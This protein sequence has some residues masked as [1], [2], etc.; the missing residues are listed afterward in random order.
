MY[1]FSTWDKL[2]SPIGG[3]SLAF[4][5]NIQQPWPLWCSHQGRDRGLCASCSMVWQ[6]S[7]SGSRNLR[8]FMPQREGDMNLFSQRNLYSRGDIWPWVHCSGGGHES[9]SQPCIWLYLSKVHQGCPQQGYHSGLSGAFCTCSGWKCSW[10][11]TLLCGE[12]DDF[13]W[14]VR[15]VL[16][17][18]VITWHEQGKI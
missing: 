11:K 4:H 1:L 2:V 12:E 3:L 17:C 5:N 9:W 16:R 14:K 13:P 7:I 8:A 10:L 15:Q 6:E 18:L